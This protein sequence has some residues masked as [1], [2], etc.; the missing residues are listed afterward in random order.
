[1]APKRAH[2]RVNQEGPLTTPIPDPENM[3]SKGKALQRQAFGSARAVDSGIQNDTH[4]SISK[5]PLVESPATETH[6]YQEVENLSQVSKVEEP[7]FSSNITESV[8]EVD[9]SSH[10]KELNTESFQQK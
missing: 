2:T 4:P 5:N 10:P 7:S 3:I 8:L 1:V 9:V 6:N